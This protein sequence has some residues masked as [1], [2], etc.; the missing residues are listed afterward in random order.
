MAP[1]G[2]RVPVEAVED[3]PLSLHRLLS[4]VGTLGLRYTEARD[5]ELVDTRDDL[6]RVRELYKKVREKNKIINE[7]Q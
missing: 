5:K 7:Q 1:T 2:E 3:L 4:K 6:N